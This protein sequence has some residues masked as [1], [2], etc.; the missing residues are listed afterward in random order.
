[1]QTFLKARDSVE[2]ALPVHALLPNHATAVVLPGL[3][4][5][6]ISSGSIDDQTVRLTLLDRILLRWLSQ[7]PTQAKAGR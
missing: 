1:M 5:S 7:H 2:P 3:H 6:D 4:P